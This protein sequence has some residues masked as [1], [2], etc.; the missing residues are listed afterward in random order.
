VP[1]TSYTLDVTKQIGSDAYFFTSDLIDA[2]TTGG[3]FAKVF[4]YRMDVTAPTGAIMLVDV[5]CFVLFCVCSMM[6]I[7]FVFSLCLTMR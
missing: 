3:F 5:S 2:N 6:Q 7:A 4:R 1:P